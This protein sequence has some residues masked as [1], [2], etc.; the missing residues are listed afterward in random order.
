MKGVL[1]VCCYSLLDFPKFGHDMSKIIQKIHW[2]MLFFFT[3]CGWGWVR[4]FLDPCRTCRLEIHRSKYRGFLQ[5]FLAEPVLAYQSSPESLCLLLPTTY[6]SY[7]YCCYYYYSY[8][9]SYYYYS[10]SYNCN[11]NYCYYMPLLTHINTIYAG[12]DGYSNNKPPL[13]YGF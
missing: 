12:I 9:Y 1:T 5:V 8:F 10:S 11:Y 7:Y 13:F 2:M 4:C 3:T 6:S